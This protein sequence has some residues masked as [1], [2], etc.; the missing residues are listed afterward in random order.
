MPKQGIF[1]THFVYLDAVVS[2]HYTM[3][4]KFISFFFCYCERPVKV[5]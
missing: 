1:L 5:L 3:S 4:M 2:Y